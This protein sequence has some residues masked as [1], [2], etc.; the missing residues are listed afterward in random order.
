MSR[1]YTLVIGGKSNNH[2]LEKRKKKNHKKTTCGMWKYGNTKH[3]LAGYRD[4]GVC[5]YAATNKNENVK[6]NDIL[7]K[8]NFV[9]IAA[10]LTNV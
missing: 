10:C 8:L 1:I 3:C 9:K 7:V 5:G 4:K 6:N 2:D